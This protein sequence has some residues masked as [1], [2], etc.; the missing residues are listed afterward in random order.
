[1][2]KTLKQIGNKRPIFI[3]TRPPNQYPNYKTCIHIK[4]MDK[5][6]GT[7]VFF[8]DMLGAQ[9]SSEIDEFSTR[10]RRKYIDVY[11]NSQSIFGLTRQSIR[12]NSDRIILFK[13]G[14]GDVENMYTDIGA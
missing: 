13:Q 14:L 3:I 6:N 1:M 11:Y 12:N 7:G 8:A 2:S 5:D 10:G 9:N 4:P